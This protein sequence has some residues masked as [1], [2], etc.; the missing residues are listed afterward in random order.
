[1][2]TDIFKE[3]E[4]IGSQHKLWLTYAKGKQLIA[5]TRQQ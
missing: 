4:F 1:M 2:G 3:I 5:V